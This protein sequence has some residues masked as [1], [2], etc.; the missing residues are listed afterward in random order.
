MKADEAMDRSQDDIEEAGWGLST[1]PATP[2][3]ER[4]QGKR[5]RMCT[6]STPV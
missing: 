3:D 5:R 6:L 2:D 1:L 4:S